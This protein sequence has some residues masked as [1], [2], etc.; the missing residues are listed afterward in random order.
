MLIDEA[1]CNHPGTVYAVSKY[2]TELLGFALGARLSVH[3]GALRYTYVQGTRNSIFNAYSGVSRRF[4]MRLRDHLPPVCYEDGQQ[5]RDYVNVRDVALANLLVL[6][7]DAANG[8]TFNV[9][10]GRAVSVLEL[11]EI[12]IKASEED[13]DPVVRGEFR[14]GDTRHTVSNIARIRSL[15]W[16]PTVSVEN[17]IAEYLVWV[18]TQP[19]TKEYLEKADEEMRRSGVV[20]ASAAG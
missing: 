16:E 8:L 17:S 2:S 9:G 3:T 7:N 15:G 13:L 14:V 10:G 6:E 1:T 5:L 19:E 12:M 20:R 18:E 4:A 11:A